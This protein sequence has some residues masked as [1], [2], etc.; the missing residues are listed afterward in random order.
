MRGRDLVTG[1]PREVKISDTHIRKAISQS[2]VLL[3]DSVKEVLEIT[4]PEIISDILNRGLFLLA[5]GQ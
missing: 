3:L 4:P 5:E 2:L 1:L